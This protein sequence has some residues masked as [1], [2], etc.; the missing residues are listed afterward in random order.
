MEAAK[1]SWEDFRSLLNGKRNYSDSKFVPELESIPADVTCSYE[2]FALGENHP[3]PPIFHGTPKEIP[4]FKSIFDVQENIPFDEYQDQIE[5][6][7]SGFPTLLP[8]CMHGGGMLSHPD[9]DAVSIL[10]FICIFRK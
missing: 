8:T 4:E 1:K 5:G 6:Q 10:F 3:R 2:L 9:E 7:T